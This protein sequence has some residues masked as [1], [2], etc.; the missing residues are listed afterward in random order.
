MKRTKEI[1]VVGYRPRFL[2]FCQVKFSIKNL[3]IVATDENI[4]I[5]KK[6]KLWY[7]QT[8]TGMAQKA[9]F[10]RIVCYRYTSKLSIVTDVL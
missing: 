3:G 5:Q 8:N 2:I 9:I 10:S 7:I 6:S 4:S 1:E